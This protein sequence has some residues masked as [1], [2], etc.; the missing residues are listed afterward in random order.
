MKKSAVFLL[1]ILLLCVLPF[2]AFA[3]DGLKISIDTNA[4]SVYMECLDTGDVIYSKGDES[5]RSPASLTKIMTALV[6]LERCDDIKNTL[7]TSPDD[8]LYSE[9][10]KE[11]GA[12]IAI[13]SDE[14][15]TC[16]DLLYA[17]MLPSA[18]D[19]AEL[20]AYHF[21]G[22]SVESFVK[23]MNDKV[24][25]L[26][27]ENTCFANPHGL[28]AQLHYSTARDMGIILKEALKNS[29]FKKITQSL[30]YTIPATSR[31][32]ERR[33]SYTIAMLNP[34]SSFYYE[35][36]SGVKSGFTSQAGR[37]LASTAEREGMELCL[38]V[39]GANLNAEDKNQGNLAYTDTKN[40]YDYAFN[41]FK[42]EKVLT[43]DQ[44]LCNVEV[45]EGGLSR[46]E[47]VCPEDVYSLCYK[48]A[49]ITNKLQVPDKLNAP[50]DIEPLGKAE[51]YADDQLI[52]SVELFPKYA[53]NHVA[54][55]T[56]AAP[57]PYTTSSEGNILTN[58]PTVIILI[59]SALAFT[60]VAI[61]VLTL[62]NARKL[63]NKGR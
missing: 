53:V 36:M 59:L 13:K 49:V 4:Q 25:E 9:I 60:L 24:S 42:V 30:D 55:T 16:E 54:P 8:G 20:L 46:V 35:G 19:A 15:F 44:V 34:Q 47:L 2:N 52:K 50:F 10:I 5:R 22:G 45:L 37:C 48:N 43:K 32:K 28:E 39:M 1:I 38:V 27:L 33:L 6:V 57:S 58:D 26:G 11:G 56:T 51:V 17:M 14:V 62:I 41:N 23:M 7:I 3:D 18:C 12:N 63:K 29:E 61:L 31:S 21:G 40:L